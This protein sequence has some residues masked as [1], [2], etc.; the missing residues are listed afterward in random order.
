MLAIYGRSLFRESVEAWKYGPVEPIVYKKFK[1]F[2][3]NH[4]DGSF[5]DLSHCFDKDELDIMEQVVS[6]YGD[7]TGIQLSSLT[8]QPDSPWDTTVK[9]LGHNSII[10][11]DLIKQHYRSLLKSD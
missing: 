3:R 6:I 11:N 2:G 4:I 8:H 5:K 10:P 7:Y 9:I 1:K